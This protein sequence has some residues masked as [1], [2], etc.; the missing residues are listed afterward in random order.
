[1]VIF[2]TGGVLICEM[3]HEVDIGGIVR[4]QTKRVN[5]DA[6]LISLGGV[7]VRFATF[8]AFARFP[9]F[10]RF[11]DFTVSIITDN[12][13]WDDTAFSDGAITQ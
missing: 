1:M 6:D 2:I 11:F 8:T 10:F 5:E 7:I 12:V 3:Q 4:D 9:T 13:C